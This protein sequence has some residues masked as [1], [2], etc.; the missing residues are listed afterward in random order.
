MCRRKGEYSSILWTA[1]SKGGSAL[2]TSSLPSLWE[3]C[4]SGVCDCT[5]RR[6]VMGWKG[7]SQA[8]FGKGILLQA[9]D[10]LLPGWRGSFALWR[11]LCR[12]WWI[13]G[14]FGCYPQ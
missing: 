13:P 7:F 4:R 6:C 1:Q 3:L 8:S 5:D 9:A 12:T 14:C 10:E 2:S 11:V